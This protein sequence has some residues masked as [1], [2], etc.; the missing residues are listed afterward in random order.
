MPLALD[1][2]NKRSRKVGEW[3]EVQSDTAFASFELSLVANNITAWCD[4][5][6]P[7]FREG[8]CETHKCIRPVIR[9]EGH[10]ELP[11]EVFE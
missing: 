7:F 9:I 3:H 10:T 11:S 1:F 8:D 4:D 5:Q 2:A 6:D